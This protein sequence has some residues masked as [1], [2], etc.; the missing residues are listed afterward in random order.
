MDVVNYLIA[1]FLKEQWANV[2][3]LI[4]MSSLISLLQTRGLS[5]L[6]ANIITSMQ[7]KNTL[8]AVLYFKYFIVTLLFFVIV[9]YLFNN[10]FQKLLNQIRQWVR[11]KLVQMLIITNNEQF[12]S[13]NFIN[14]ITP[15][16]RAVVVCHSI[17]HNIIEYLV[18]NVTFLIIVFGFFLYK[19][20]GV[21]TIF[22]IGNI[23][24]CLYLASNW[25]SM[26][27]KLNL[28]ESN[29]V[30]A[31]NNINEILNN[32]DKIIH[33]GQSTVEIDNFTKIENDN[34]ALASDYQ[35]STNYHLFISN[36]IVLITVTFCIAYMIHIYFK[37][38]L[39]ITYFITFIT[40]LTLYREK[41][42]WALSEIP[43]YI[44]IAGRSKVIDEQFIKIKNEYELLLSKSRLKSD[45]KF[46][47]IKFQNIFFKYDKKGS[48]VLNNLNL[49]I[50]TTGNKIIGFTGCSGKGKSTLV[51]MIIK[52]YKPTSGDIFIDGHNIN[53]IDPNYLRQNITY[54]NQ[55]SKLF[56][57]KIVDNIMYGCY[58][59]N[60][61]SKYYEEI[62]KYPKIDE[63]YKNINFDNMTAGPMGE[64]L[65][66]GQRQV[67]NLISGLI[68]PSKILI[69]DE[70][71]NALDPE[72]K[73]EVLNIIRDFKKYKQ[74]ILIITHDNDVYS[75]FDEHINI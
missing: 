51:K 1:T 40:I 41:M 5:F 33:R 47:N 15:I 18:P 22:L 64:K 53:D 46:E 52:L 71:T 49:E 63:L 72:L 58:D 74:C 38:Q 20:N 61:C 13:I 29:V 66:G 43:S 56:D 27:A 55:N 8:N 59:P 48:D 67:V 44:E 75:L 31:E 6:S 23:L 30:T 68:N 17:L 28:Y 3:L 57:R 11:S 19:N 36:C 65:S 26:R 37:K 7:T 14:L 2:S 60:I 50:N 16:T 35:S 24:L 70:P 4:I 10:I 73:H 9:S 62:L 32:M 54:V 39:S 12:T 45:L 34:T 69:L 25:E 42:E 21:A